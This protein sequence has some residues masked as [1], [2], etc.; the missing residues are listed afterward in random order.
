M[1]Y[2]RIFLR[3]LFGAGATLSDLKQRGDRAPWM[4]QLMHKGGAAREQPA[5]VTVRICTSCW[6]QLPAAD[7]HECSNCGAS[8]EDS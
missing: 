1:N 3:R 8:L 7:Q 2:Y 4:A 5:V 6:L